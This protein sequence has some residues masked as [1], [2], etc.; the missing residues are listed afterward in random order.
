MF[1]KNGSPF[2]VNTS[3]S[4]LKNISMVFIAMAV[5]A[6]VFADIVIAHVD[7]WFEL[8]KIGYGLVTPDFFSTE[9]LLT[10]LLYTL[11]FA[12]VGT[13]LGNT[14]GFALALLFEFRIVRFFCAFI[15]SIHEIFW[16][17]LFLQVFGLSTITGVLAIAIPFAGIFAKVYA[18]ILEEADLSPLNSLHPKTSGISRYAYARLPVV[19]HHFCH[20]SRYRLECSI[21]SSAILGFVGLPTLGF[22][23]ETAFSQGNYSE[24]A[25]LLYV[26][27]ILIAS[28]KYW[29]KFRIMPLL[30]LASWWFL[31]NT[32][33]INTS[34]ITRFFTVDIIPPPLRSHTSDGAALSSPNSA[35]VIAWLQDAIVPQALTGVVNTL[36]VSF[37]ALVLT[38]F[39]SLLLFPWLSK[40]FFGRT[41]RGIGHAFLIVFRTIPELIL[42]FVFSLFLGPSMLPAIL[43]LALHN[44]SI[45][46]YLISHHADAIQ[47][48]VDHHKN[49]NLYFFE[50]LPRIY[51]Q[52]LA[53]LFY[54]WEVIIRETAILGLLGVHTLG[55]YV[56][57]A[58]EDLRFDRA[59]VFILITAALN[60]CV[61]QLS[62]Y[63]RQ[64][65]KPRDFAVDPSGYQPT[66]Q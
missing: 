36:L 48:R 25:A 21:R 15:R 50:V 44:G 58:F 10:S 4:V 5:I 17:L 12:V 37:I 24:A 55:F 60:L 19:W 6:T 38:G 23:L 41:Y 30:M 66:C 46:A 65:S 51:N 16:A 39:I 8:G 34:N 26:F 31:P 35:E 13:V 2:T 43:A 49:L 47:L 63:L 14:A 32:S 57:S 56:D 11:A 53:F 9:N 54:R 33:P 27:F 61:D 62:R 52:F 18:E 7:P 45:I 29:A 40:L 59:V 28:I 20:Y 22:H 64:R 42:A 3:A 1:K